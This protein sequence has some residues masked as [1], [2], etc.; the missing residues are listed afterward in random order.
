MKTLQITSKSKADKILIDSLF[1]PVNGKTLS[2][3]KFDGGKYKVKPDKP[4]IGREVE[5][6]ESIHA[7]Y[8]VRRKDSDGGYIALH[9]VYEG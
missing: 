1:N 4:Y 8:P 6:D 3:I 5:C 9:C 2:V 7:I